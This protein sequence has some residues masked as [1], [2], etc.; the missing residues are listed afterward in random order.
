MRYPPKT[1]TCAVIVVVAGAE[2]LKG[3]T[4]GTDGILAARARGIDSVSL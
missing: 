3:G 4:T 2:R 1:V